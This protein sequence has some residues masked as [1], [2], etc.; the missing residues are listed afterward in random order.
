MTVKELIEKLQTLDQDLHVFTDGYEGGFQYVEI[1][2]PDTFYLNVNTEW[3]YGP[4][5]NSTGV[6]GRDKTNYKQI[7]GIVL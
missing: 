6:A 7:K 1:R 4:H 3:Y 5:E 2:E